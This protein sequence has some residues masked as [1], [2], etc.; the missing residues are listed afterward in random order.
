MENPFLHG[1][2]SPSI[3]PTSSVWLLE[4]AHRRRAYTMSPLFSVQLRCTSFQLPFQS[5]WW[6]VPSVTIQK[7]GDSISAPCFCSW[8]SCWHLISSICSKS[9]GPGQVFP[10]AKCSPVVIH[11]CVS[12]AAC[13]ICFLFLACPAASLP[14]R[15]SSLVMFSTIWF[16]RVP[17]SPSR[18][19]SWSGVIEFLLLCEIL[20]NGTTHTKFR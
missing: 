4:A 20:F 5:L 2:K 17:E 13:A 10:T 1:N 3:L 9:D 15:T 12:I 14:F 8:I 19:S 18:R 16:V 7:T 11:L 6:P